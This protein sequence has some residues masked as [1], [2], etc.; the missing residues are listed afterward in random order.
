M[1]FVVV[2]A[3][4]IVGI[5]PLGTPA[6]DVL[7]TVAIVLLVGLL[8]TGI[9]MAV[10]HYTAGARGRRRRASASVGA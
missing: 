8:I 10:H 9:W 4:L 7:S 2:A 3:I 5:L 6:G 1:A